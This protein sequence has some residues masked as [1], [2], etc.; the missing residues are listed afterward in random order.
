MM[1][2]HGQFD[3]QYPVVV[4]AGPHMQD[5]IEGCQ[6]DQRRQPERHFLEHGRQRI[7]CRG[8]QPADQQHRQDIDDQV[9]GQG[10]GDQGRVLEHDQRA[11]QDRDLGQIQIIR[12]QIT[13]VVFDQD[14][15]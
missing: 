9:V 12:D 13:Q 8:Q 1:A 4:D 3:H 11:E 7:G 6:M 14:R 5:P 2:D 15:A 10:A